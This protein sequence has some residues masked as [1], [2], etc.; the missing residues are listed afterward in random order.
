MF[1]LLTIIF[2]MAG[3]RVGSG[4]IWGRLAAPKKLR[5]TFRMLDVC[6]I[7][8]VPASTLSTLCIAPS[9]S[10]F[11]VLFL[12]VRWTRFYL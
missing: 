10:H 1:P 3:L 7:G 9:K 11:L 4:S 2:G 8:R 6:Q 12:G 5:R